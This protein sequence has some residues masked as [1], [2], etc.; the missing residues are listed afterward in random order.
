MTMDQFPP[1]MFAGLIII[2]LIGFPV[3]FSLAALG[4]ASGFYAIQMGWFPA[5]FMGNLPISIFSILNN[6]LL[7]AI[8]FFT[9]M[10]TILEKCGLAEDMLDSMGQLFGPA[11]GGIGYSVIIVGFI[12][13]AITGTVAGQV[14]AMALISLPVMM[15]YNYNMRYTTGVLAAS[16]TITQLVPPS[17]VLVVLADQLGRPVGDM[18]KG[19]WGPSLLQVGMFMIYTFLLTRIKPTYLPAIPITERTLNGWALWKKCLRGI[20]PS[21]ILIFTVLGSMGGLP[22]QDTAIA[23]P[24]EAGA[25]GVVGALVLAAI[26]RR[27][28]IALIWEAMTGTMRLTAMVVFILIGSRVFSQVFQGV[29]GAKWVEHMLTGLPGGQIGFLIVVNVFVFFLAFFLD[30]FEIAF[31]IVPMLAPVADKMGIDLIWFGVLLCVNLQTSFMHPPFGFALFYL[32][33]I[34]DTLF[35]DKRIPVPVQSNDIYLGAIPWVIMQVILV[36]IVIF[37]PQSVTMFLDKEVKVDID[38]VKIEMPVE[39]PPVKAELKSGE[40]PVAKDSIPLEAA[41][42]KAAQKSADD[43]QKKIDDLFKK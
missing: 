43:D 11:R 40:S 33:G 39:E 12:L 19:A 1:I 25:M 7:L 4:L 42:D 15:K 32:R 3:A 34:A 20:V 30:F 13:G 21:A 23:T 10:G 17:L 36:F 14:I 2:M 8:P 5:A 27:L 35:K 24:T 22:F 41:A 31:I 29:D 28:T 6:E 37:V 26:S 18:Y 9:F 38:K 16:G